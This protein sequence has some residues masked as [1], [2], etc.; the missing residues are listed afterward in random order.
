VTQNVVATQP[1]TSNSSDN[2]AAFA[3]VATGA[4]WTTEM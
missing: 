2:D 4:D 3:E 1:A